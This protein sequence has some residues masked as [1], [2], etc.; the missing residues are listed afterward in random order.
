[1]SI[2]PTSDLGKITFY[3]AHIPVWTADASAIGLKDSDCA[4]LQALI[5]AAR[6]AWDAQQAA[7]NASKAATTTMH[8]AVRAMHALGATDI[9]KIKA[10]AE[11]TGNPDVYALAEIP[12]P[13]TPSPVGPPGTPTDFVV[14][15]MQTGAVMLKWKCA[16]PSGA[17]GTIYNLSRRIGGSGAFMPIGGTGVRSFTDETIPA[18]STMLTYQIVAVR[19]TRSGMPALFNVNFGMGGDGLMVATV[20]DEAPAMKMAA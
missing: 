10:F 6:A 9:A 3:E 1:M 12:A 15:L 18:G 5:S 16:N 11:A 14:T 2:V 17:S 20:S 19:S 13:A 8:N 7:A 4:D